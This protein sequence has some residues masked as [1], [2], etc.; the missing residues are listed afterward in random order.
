MLKTIAMG[1]PEDERLRFTLDYEED[2]QFF[3][4]LIEKTGDMIFGMSDEDIVNI[5]LKEKMC[6]YN[7]KIAKQYWED[8]KKLQ[9]QEMEKSK[10]IDP[11]EHKERS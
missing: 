5:V 9:K 3:R 4:V 11:V 6:R 7:E 10:E 2:Y 1:L 8:F